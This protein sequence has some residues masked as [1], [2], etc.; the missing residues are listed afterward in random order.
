MIQNIYKT[1]DN[2]LHRMLYYFLTFIVDHAL[3]KNIY[4]NNNKIN[5]PNLYL[6]I[7]IKLI[8]LACLFVCLGFV[9]L[10]VCLSVWAQSEAP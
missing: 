10:F 7:L 5:I 9:C 3:A 1:V 4:I 6:I 8:N 2:I